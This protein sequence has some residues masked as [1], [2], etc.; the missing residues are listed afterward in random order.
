MNL[1]SSEKKKILTLSRL[2]RS[3][4]FLL[5]QCGYCRGPKRI[6][7]G[8]SPWGLSDLLFGLYGLRLRNMKEECD[9]RSVPVETTCR[10]SQS[11]AGAASA[12]PLHWKLEHKAVDDKKPI[13]PLG[14][15]P[16][17]V[18]MSVLVICRAASGFSLCRFTAS[19]GELL[20]ESLPALEILNKF[21]LPL[22]WSILE[23]VFHLPES[24]LQYWVGCWFNKFQ[25][26]QS[27]TV[28]IHLK[29]PTGR[30]TVTS[31]VW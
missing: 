14:N 6:I 15:L 30:S 12:S 11:P 9:W 19:R 25:D 23:L 22:T 8:L 18:S 2:Q 21:Q 26:A 28:K 31:V 24:E 3:S 29:L 16:A 17:A 27:Q 10:Q 13:C 7:I 5:R 20:L 1:L 4:F